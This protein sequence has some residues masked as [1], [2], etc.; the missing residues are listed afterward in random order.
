MRPLSQLDEADCIARAQRGEVAAFT[1]LVARNQ[2]L[3]RLRRSRLWRGS[4][5][6][7]ARRVEVTLK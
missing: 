1:E 3:D 4:P 5:A 2:A 6:A 7:E